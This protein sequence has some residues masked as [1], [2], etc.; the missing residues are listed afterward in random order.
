[1][2]ALPSIM[3]PPLQGIPMTNSKETLFQIS[4]AVY[5][6]VK[7]WRFGQSLG[8]DPLF[9]DSICSFNCYYCQLGNIEQHTM[10]RREYVATAKVVEDFRAVTDGKPFDVITYSGNGEP[11]LATN[12]GEIITALR[13][14][15]QVEQVILTNGTTLL[16]PE[17][18]DTLCQLDRVS[19]KLDAGSEELFQRI[20]RPVAGVTLQ[21]VVDGIHTLK[22]RF[23]GE[24]EIQTMFS[25]VNLDDLDSYIELINNL[26]PDL[27][28]LN[29]PTRPY[30]AEW[31]RENRGNHL[32]QFDCKVSQL[33]IITA[34]EGR[35]VEERIR[36][37]TGIPVISNFPTISPG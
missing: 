4:R 12:L 37:E 6:P 9:V 14:L 28:Q 10:A 34:E 19:V 22:A 36:R 7:S 26:R 16:I 18:V 1:M 33:K 25:A 27:L 21:S 35:R 8:I 15:S 24:L 30:P 13:A 23:P 3:Q 11:T 32:Q 5:G 17:V 20:N 2:A 29:T 31:H